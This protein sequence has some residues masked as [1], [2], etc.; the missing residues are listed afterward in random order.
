[1]LS[2]FPGAV[3]AEEGITPPPVAT[4]FE[5]GAGDLLLPKFVPESEADSD[6]GVQLIL[7]S[8]EDY[9]P[10]TLATFASYYFTD[11]ANLSE[12]SPM[13]DHVF[14]AGAT[15]TYLPILADNLYGEATVR[16]QVFLYNNLS[17]LD[18][19]ALD[20]GAGL[21]YVSRSLGDTSFYTRYNYAQFSDPTF[22][23]VDFAEYKNHSIQAG[24]YKG[25]ILSRNHFAFASWR[26]DIS[27]DGDPGYSQRDDHS[28]VIG[29]RWTPVDR[30]KVECFYRAAFLDFDI[31]REDWNHGTGASV[32]YNFTPNL[33]LSGFFS[34]TDN[35][36][37]LD[38]DADYQAWQPGIQFGGN[39]KF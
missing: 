22:G 14:T 5:F 39:W 26:S 13:E 31:G 18:F 25:W 12:S 6:I 28:L 38:I 10:V 16:D 9:E 32:T 35:D 33:Y 8:R 27:L 34:Y 21:V 37:N 1:M 23:G 36:T 3:S 4:E 29:Y 11:N 24:L 7:Q 20:I 19:N 30:I 17:G 15:L 2:G